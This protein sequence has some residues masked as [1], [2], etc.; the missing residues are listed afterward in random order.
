MSN[1]SG[2]YNLMAAPD[3]AFQDTGRTSFL[4]FLLA[5]Y[6]FLLIFRPYE[7]WPVLG[8]LHIERVYML[9]F[10]GI[11]F[12]N[13]EK[14]F[15]PSPVNGMVVLFT[16]VLLVSGV[17]AYRWDPAWLLFQDYLKYVI[18]YFMVILSVR[19]ER[20]LRNLV[21]AF[22]AVMAIYVGKSLW[23]FT[24][25]GRYVWRMG[26]ARLCG[27]DNTYGDPNSF[28]ATIC[29]SL[30]LTW[31][32]IRM[33]LP[34]K[35]L[36]LGLWGYEGM[37]IA[38]IILTGS[39]SGM[40][41]GLFFLGLVLLGSSR[42]MGSALCI[43]LVLLVSWNFMPEDLQ[44]RFLSLFEDV[45]PAS[46]ENS[47]AGRL[48]G[49]LHGVE[50]FTQHPLLG[51]GPSN[52]PYS[53]PGVV[54]GMNAHNLYGQ[55]MGELGLAGV[56]AF[57]CLLWLVWSV[58]RRMTEGRKTLAR[59]YAEAHAPPEEDFGS[60]EAAA[61]ASAGDVDPPAAHAAHSSP[62]GDEAEDEEDGASREWPA[63][64]ATDQSREG[65][66]RR[67][68]FLALIGQAVMQTIVLMLF[69]GWGDHNLYRYNWLWVA[70][71]TVLAY[72]FYKQELSAYEAH[73]AEE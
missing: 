43:G 53:W 29:Y 56:V 54:D 50:V 41:T 11:A 58:S 60:T 28:A 30:P 62:A 63:D 61:A 59:E 47:A 73:D 22:A 44:T 70:A 57:G 48:E 67:M 5:G 26:I 24:F 55:T 25:H 65:I 14:R 36:R 35:W 16:G 46:A 40:M 31:A 13:K 71:L 3:E 4:T 51:I 64:W 72:D 34:H 27:V 33:K 19:D 21:V 17:L 49:F 12:L 7:Y 32:A 69:K 15:V 18:F 23:E 8:E 20:D 10:M 68:G 38:A 52:F 42:K 6:L 66:L 2:H 45:G 9:M 39:R 1:G 37:A